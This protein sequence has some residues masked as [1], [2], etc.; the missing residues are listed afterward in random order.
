M[1]K[2]NLKFAAQ[3]MSKEQM[4]NVTGGGLCPCNIVGCM[5]EDGG[6]VGF[7]SSPTCTTD[8]TDALIDTCATMYAG[9]PECL[10]AGPGL[11]PVNPNYCS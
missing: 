6:F 5:T 8:Q 7:Y 1:K 2:L 4:K 10:C 11:P 9:S 3:K